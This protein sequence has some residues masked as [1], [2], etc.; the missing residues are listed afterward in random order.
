MCVDLGLSGEEY[1]DNVVFVGVRFEDGDRGDS[2]GKGS[3][4]GIFFFDL[5]GEAHGF[6]LDLIAA[7]ISESL[8]LPIPP[9]RG[10]VDMMAWVLR[11]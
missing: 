10:G 8:A 1:G 11:L 7:S 5:S 4:D 2:I 3:M 9:F 6:A